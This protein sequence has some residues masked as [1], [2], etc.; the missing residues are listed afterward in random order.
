MAMMVLFAILPLLGEFA[1]RQYVTLVIMM[2]FYATLASAWDIMGG[3]AGQVSLGNAGFL[4]IGAYTST[5][6]FLRFGISPWVGMFIGATVAGLSSFVIGLTALRLKGVF[7]VMSSLAFVQVVQLLLT[8]F[9]SVTNGD[10][11]LFIPLTSNPTQ[12]QFSQPIFYAWLIDG[13]L[14]LAIFANYSI[15]KRRIGF[16]LSAIREDEDAAQALGINTGLYK[17]LAFFIS[18]FITGMV[19][20]FYAQYFLFITPT[21]TATIPL[22]IQIVLAAIIGGTGKIWGPVFGG[23]VFEVLTYFL[24]LSFPT[25]AGLNYTII[26]ALLM[27]IVI[28][29]P[30]G[31]LA[32]VERMIRSK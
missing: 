17:S 21:S 28:V 5:L 2:F 26:G 30:Q 22:S 14:F 16:Y 25:I 3:R 6:L 15:S 4:A 31:F 1:G 11:G 19:G 20:A 23:I 10:I 32:L 8:H 18:A 27:L 24:Q 9:V 29:S 13:I 7:F 12:M